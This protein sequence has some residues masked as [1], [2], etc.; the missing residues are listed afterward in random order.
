MKAAILAAV[1]AIAGLP[2]YANDFAPAMS[3][4]LESEI[5]AW[6]NDPLI[7]EAIEAQ[8]TRT[9]GLTQAEI[10]AM[11]LA[12][13]S[14]IGSAARP[15]IDPVL[16][17]AAA[18]FLRARREAS[19]GII[20]EIFT[21]DARGLNVAASDMTS[22]FWQGDEAKHSETF[23]KGA[24]SIHIGEVEFDESTQTYQGQ[25]SIVVSD[26]ETGAPVGAMTIGVN[27]EMM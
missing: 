5:S 19:G 10:D 20:T 4:Y 1:A 3:N 8:N 15:T 14:E 26:P 17:S 27:A 25:I 11:D 2:A 12:W 7:V 23:G 24:G 22:D 9:S 16:H 21:M 13:R 18:D 6:M